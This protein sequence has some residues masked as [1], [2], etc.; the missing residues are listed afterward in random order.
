MLVGIGQY[1]Y[2]RMDA[3]SFSHLARNPGI[4]FPA[5][6]PGSIMLITASETQVPIMSL[7]NVFILFKCPFMLN[8]LFAVFNCFNVLCKAL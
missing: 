6:L 7:M 8:C 4:I 5:Y 1:M 2:D 3:V